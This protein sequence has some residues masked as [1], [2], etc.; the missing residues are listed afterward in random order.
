MLIECDSL[1]KYA[2]NFLTFNS[3]V[4]DNLG[5]SFA[6][7]ISVPPTQLPL[8]YFSITTKSKIRKTI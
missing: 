1:N 5:C 7:G 2:L 8:N 6:N 4:N 3:E